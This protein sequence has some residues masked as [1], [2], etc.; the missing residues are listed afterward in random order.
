MWAAWNQMTQLIENEKWFQNESLCNI[1]VVCHL[2]KTRIVQMFVN[3]N[4]HISQKIDFVDAMK[5]KLIVIDLSILYSRFHHS[6]YNVTNFI[7]N[8]IF[9]FVTNAFRYVTRVNDIFRLKT[10]KNSMFFIE[11]LIVSFND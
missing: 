2:L 4:I 1:N 11:S 9:D 7:N 5:T 10:E 6:Q 3:Q 8:V